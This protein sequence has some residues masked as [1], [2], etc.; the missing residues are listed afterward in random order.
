MLNSRCRSCIRIFVYV[1]K[2][3]VLSQQKCLT[4]KKIISE[5][6]ILKPLRKRMIRTNR[7]TNPYFTKKIRNDLIHTFL[8]SL[9]FSKVQ[10]CIIYGSL[11]LGAACA[12]LYLSIGQFIKI[13]VCFLTSTKIMLFI[14]FQ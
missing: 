5:D 3:P 8:S 2:V 1:K 9:I 13:A 11:A 12:E 10:F 7:V 6:I 14:L 4:D